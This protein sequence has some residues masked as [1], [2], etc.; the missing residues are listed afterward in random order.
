MNNLFKRISGFRFIDKYISTSFVIVGVALAVGF[1]NKE[2]LLFYDA[3]GHVALIEQMRDFWPAFSGWDAGHLLGWPQ[4]TFYPSLFH[5]LAAA[6]SF[7]IGVGP[8]VKLLISASIV[9]LPFSI[10]LFASSLMGNKFWLFITTYILLLL[11]LLFPNFLGTGFRSLF[12][13]GLLS[14]FFVLPIMFL[15]LA[16]VHNKWNYAL[17]AILLSLVILTHIV[18]AIVAGAYLLIFAYSKLYLGESFKETYYYL[19]TI[20]VASLLT[21]FFWV[22]FVVNLEFTSV[23]RH[24]SS[25]LW[26]NVGVLIISYLLTVFTKEKEKTVYG[27]GLF[28]TFFSA[29]LVVD[30]IFISRFGT[31]FELYQLHLYRFQPFVYLLIVA[32]IMV[33]VSKWKR[34][35]FLA[36]DKDLPKWTP[37]F[38]LFLIALVLL[39]RSPAKVPQASFELNSTEKA[40][41]RFIETF[42]RS[43]ADPF[44]YGFQEELAK[45]DG[46]QWAYGLFTDS[47]PN[48]PYVGSLIKSLRPQAYPEGEE[49]FMET[50]VVDR[51]R[52]ESLINHFGINYLINLEDEPKISVGILSKEGKKQYYNVQKVSDSKVFEIISLELEPVEKNWDKQV[53]EW[54]LAEG[55]VKTLPYLSSEEPPEYS[56]EKISSAKVKV[57]SANSKKTQFKLNVSAKEKVPVLARIS[58]FPYWTAR[59]DGQEIQIYRAAPNLILFFANGEVSLEYKTPIWQNVL[60]IF[61]ATVFLVVIFRHRKKSS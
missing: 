31:S 42:R 52:V 46:T 16:S 61:S 13:I 41:G 33:F 32:A 1:L 26:L 49:S 28:G 18:V 47:S 59:Q 30:A 29:F 55:P 56:Q 4:G 10:F 15:F 36:K 12:Q 34:F 50:K 35:D 7:L 48:G 43:E 14:N 45:Q 58:Y 23:S 11:L 20:G 53:E 5:W 25:Y 39:V 54:W 57:I 22:P 19:K 24:V 60:Y 37:L 51:Q 40:S 2:S 8:A 3:A 6:F 27:L 44:W 38:G 21:V 17:S 9:A